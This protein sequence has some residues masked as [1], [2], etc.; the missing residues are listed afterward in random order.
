MGDNKATKRLYFLRY[1]AKCVTQ[2]D[3]AV[4]GLSHFNVDQSGGWLLLVSAD[5]PEDDYAAQQ[6]LDSIGAPSR[7]YT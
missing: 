7:R 4:A 2:F 1:G 3:I 5:E 6:F